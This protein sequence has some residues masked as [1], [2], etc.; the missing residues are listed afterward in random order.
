MDMIK[1]I[2]KIYTQLNLQR[3]Y[4]NNLFTN[5]G[6]RIYYIEKELIYCSIDININN[7]V[8]G[9]SDM[10]KNDVGIIYVELKSILNNLKN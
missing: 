2:E 4:F 9:F 5:N 6:D 7:I 8:V 3:I 1:E 10:D